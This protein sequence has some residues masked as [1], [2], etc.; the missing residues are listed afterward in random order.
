MGRPEVLDRYLAHAVPV[1][2]TYEDNKPV[3]L[4]TAVQVQARYENC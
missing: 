3:R 1:T 4:P 2:L